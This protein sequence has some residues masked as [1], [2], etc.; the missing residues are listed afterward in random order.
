[1]LAFSPLLGKAGSKGRPPMADVFGNIVEGIAQI[2][3]ATLLHVGTAVFEL[4]GLVG[5]RRHPGAGQ[6]LVRGNKPG[7]ITNPGQD[8]GTLDG[9]PSLTPEE[10]ERLKASMARSAELE[11]K[12]SSPAPEGWSFDGGR[13]LTFHSDRKPEEHLRSDYN[14]D[15]IR[16]RG[17]PLRLQGN[18]AFDRID[19]FLF[20]EVL[21][22]FICLLCR[23]AVQREKL[24]QTRIKKREFDLGDCGLGQVFYLQFPFGLLQLLG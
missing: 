22:Q 18:A 4:T 1:M 12:Q 20:Q 8:H 15:C 7:E 23:N 16:K 6:R 17:R 14:V 10:A 5:R 24:L 11:A 19:C 3:G 13:D 9:C 2:P 21:R